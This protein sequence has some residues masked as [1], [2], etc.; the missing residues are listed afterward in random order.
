MTLSTQKRL[1]QLRQG[2]LLRNDGGFRMIRQRV[3]TKREIL[4]TLLARAWGSGLLLLTVTLS[5]C[6]D[7]LPHV[8]LASPEGVR[9]SSASS[10]PAS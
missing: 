3:R 4:R 6:G 2:N 7:W 9:L 10:Q 5:A 8:D 1:C